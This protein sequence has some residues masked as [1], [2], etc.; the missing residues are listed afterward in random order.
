MGGHGGKRVRD[1]DMKPM[2]GDPFASLFFLSVCN[3]IHSLLIFDFNLIISRL[4]CCHYIAAAYIKH[5]TCM[6]SDCIYGRK[7]HRVSSQH[8]NES[9]VL[10]KALKSF[11]VHQLGKM[12]RDSMAFLYHFCSCH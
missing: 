5:P 2:E 8:K 6:V 3:S 10:T 4:G 9:F 1:R 11:Q 7:V 12:V